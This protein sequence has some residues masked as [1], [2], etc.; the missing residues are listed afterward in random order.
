[1]RAVMQT[2]LLWGE[3]GQAREML[4]NIITAPNQNAKGEA[5]RS[6]LGLIQDSAERFSFTSV[7]P[8]SSP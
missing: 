8:E 1:M 6:T 4:W 7:L 2:G 5:A 3:G